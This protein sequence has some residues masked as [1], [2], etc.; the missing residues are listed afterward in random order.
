MNKKSGK[1]TIYDVANA[2]GVSVA[3]VSRVINHP[4]TVSDETR[5]LILKQMDEMGFENKD[6]DRK[7]RARSRGVIVVDCPSNV[8]PFYDQVIKGI[9]DY[10]GRIGYTV[11]S[12][13]DSFLMEYAKPLISLAKKKAV[14]GFICMGRREEKILKDLSYIVPVVQCMEWYDPIVPSLPSVSLSIYGMVNKALTHLIE[15]GAQRIVLLDYMLTTEY[16]KQVYTAYK[17]ILKTRGIE[18]SDDMAFF[19]PPGFDQAYLQAMSCL[20]GDMPDAFI[21]AGDEF[22]AASLRAAD[23]LGIEVPEDL[24]ICGIGDC[25]YS[26]ILS[27]PISTVSG[28]GQ[29]LGEAACRLLTERIASPYDSVTHDVINSELVIRSST[30]LPSTEN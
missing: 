23:R 6:T 3:T 17:S 28:M 9:H 18:Y 5:N 16:G 15:E 2:C 14:V 19:L 7:D 1:V 25:P 27:V 21:C 29:R 22:A 12:F 13:T 26:G 20:K 30:L 4:G 10:A 24:K 11:T 8:N